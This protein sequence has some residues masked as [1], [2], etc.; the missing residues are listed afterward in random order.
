MFRAIRNWQV[1]GKARHLVGLFAFEFVVIVLGVLTAQAVAD[2]SK[3]R[4]AQRDMLKNKERADAQ[5]AFLAATSIAYGRIIPCMERRI[6]GV[7]R[8]AS[9]TGDVDSKFLVRPILWNYPYTDL[10]SESLLN[11]RAHFGDQ[12]SENYERIAVYAGRSNLLIV[13][14][15]NDWEALSI[16]SPD[17]GEVGPG[18]RQEARILA[19]RMRSTLR[20]LEKMS[21]NIVY[22]ARS[23]GVTPR[24][25]ADQ[26]L[27]EGCADLWR[28]GSVLYDPQDVPANRDRPQP[29]A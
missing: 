8:G 21:D 29:S 20:S 7:M 14:L 18:D 1:N 23:L 17:S 11:L 4:T 2:W 6:I 3:N 13:S 16:I 19:S 9:G 22:R 26:R 10:T 24:L 15:A 27:P 25:K 12:V 28:W 5:I